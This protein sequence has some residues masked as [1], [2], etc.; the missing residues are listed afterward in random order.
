MPTKS[1]PFFG[2]AYRIGIDAIVG[3]FIVP[4]SDRVATSGEI[5][6]PRN[7]GSLLGSDLLRRQIAPGLKPVPL[8]V[9]RDED[10]PMRASHGGDWNGDACV[11]TSIRKWCQEEKR[12]E[13][14]SQESP[15]PDT[16][17]PGHTSFFVEERGHDSMVAPAARQAR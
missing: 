3:V 1:V 2:Q 12:S 4:D 6:E 5:V 9:Q 16:A 11:A 15:A 10:Q 14:G 13:K 7:D 8:L 17:C